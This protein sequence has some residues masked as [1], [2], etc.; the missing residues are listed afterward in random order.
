[1]LTKA[2]LNVVVALHEGA[3]P[4]RFLAE[5]ADTQLFDRLTILRAVFVL[6]ATGLVDFE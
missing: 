3:T 2:E 6:Y 5:Y 1:M 4:E